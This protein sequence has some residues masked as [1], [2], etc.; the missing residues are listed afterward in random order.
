MQGY[1]P[2]PWLVEETRSKGV[3]EYQLWQPSSQGLI[4]DGQNKRHSPGKAANWVGLLD[5]ELLL[6]TGTGYKRDVVEPREQD[7][8]SHDFSELVSATPIWP[9]GLQPVQGALATSAGPTERIFE[10]LALKDQEIEA[11]RKRHKDDKNAVI[12]E[13]ASGEV[14]IAKL[15]A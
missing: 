8:V 5:S 2:M 13:K 6:H 1:L 3:H 12:K 10:V 15:R 14:E 11:I 7:T 4:H 9:I